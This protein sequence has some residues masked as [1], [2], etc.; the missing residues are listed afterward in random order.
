MVL[1]LFLP[2]DAGRTVDTLLRAHEQE[3]AR[4]LQP[5]QNLSAF[6][7]NAISGHTAAANMAG[8]WEANTS[9]RDGPRVPRERVA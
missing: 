8:A 6:E 5:L 9:R 4:L 3:L 2:S 7:L 1:P